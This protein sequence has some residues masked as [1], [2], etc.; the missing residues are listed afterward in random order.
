MLSCRASPH[1][2]CNRRR[3]K[4]G[5]SGRP[6]RRL[7]LRLQASWR[8]SQKP[9]GYN[10]APALVQPERSISTRDKHCV[11]LGCSSFPPSSFRLHTFQMS[12]ENRAVD[13]FCCSR[14]CTMPGY[15]HTG[16]EWCCAARNPAWSRP[17]RSHLST[18]AW[19]ALQTATTRATQ[20]QARAAAQA[21]PDVAAALLRATGRAPLPPPAAPPRASWCASSAAFARSRCTF[22][23]PSA[24]LS[25]RQQILMLVRDL[26]AVLS[27]QPVAPNHNGACQIMNGE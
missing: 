24:A 19:A 6:Q 17:A 25:P 12:T 27:G 2:A 14:G 23:G 8:H 16:R 9:W 20:S 3:R 18:W 13:E 11:G 4:R 5:E 26:E 10:T 21:H 22:C 7:L 1:D 15:S